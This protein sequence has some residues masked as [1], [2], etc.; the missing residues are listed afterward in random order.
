M[1]I[2]HWLMKLARV[3]APA[4]RAEWAHAMSAEFEALDRNANQ[5][6]WAAGCLSTVFAWRLQASALYLV[7]LVALPA[8]WNVAISRL[9][10]S[11]S[12][13]Y[14]FSQPISQEKMGQLWMALNG[15]GM[16]STLFVIT[17]ALCA[18]RPRYAIVSALVL[19]LATTG[20]TFLTMFGPQFAHLIVTAPFSAENN[21]PALPNILMALVFAGADMWPIALG[22]LAGWA[23]ARGKRFAFFAAGIAAVGL[24]IA[25]VDFFTNAGEGNSARMVF[26]MITQTSTCAAFL[27]AIVWSSYAAV[28]DFGRA[29]RAA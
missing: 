9:I 3:S 4:N 20:A 26:G 27:L 28:R 6:A 1:T 23:F 11:A 25:F 16:Q 12:T 8:L 2:A 21:H 17:A 13:T 5:I 24:T 7:A 29:W 19:W 15:A 10:F 14:A 18:Y 22:A